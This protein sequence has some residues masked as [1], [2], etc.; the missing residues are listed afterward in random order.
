MANDLKIEDRIEGMKQAVLRS[1]YFD[2]RAFDG[3]FDLE[4]PVLTGPSQLESDLGVCAQ[5]RRRI[6][7]I[8]ELLH[9][10]VVEEVLRLDEKIRD[11]DR[12]DDLSEFLRAL[13]EVV[14]PLKEEK[15]FVNVYGEL[16]STYIL[17]LYRR[18]APG[19]DSPLIRLILTNIA[20]RKA[21]EM[22]QQW[23]ETALR[24]LNEKVTIAV[25]TKRHTLYALITRGLKVLVRADIEYQDHGKSPEAL[26][27]EVTNVLL[28]AGVR[29]TEVTD[30]VCGGGDIG[31]LPDGIY[32]LTQ[33]VRDESRRRLPHSSLNLGALVAWELRELLAKQ[34]SGRLNVSLCNP[35][36]FSTLRSEDMSS[37]LK[38]ESRELSKNLRGYVKVTPL[39]SVSSLISEIL[40]ISRDRLNLV[41]LTLDGLFA[42]VVRKTGPRLIRELAAQEANSLLLDFDFTKI[43]DRLREE[44]FEIPGNLS[45]A[46]PETGTGVREICELLMI[47][48]SGKISDELKRELK[49]VVD[50]YARQVARVLEMA[51]AGRPSERPHF[52]AI[53]TTMALDPYFQTL[54]AKV[55]VRIDNPFTPMLV[56]DSLE[57]E[58][59][60]ANHLFELYV[61]GEGDRRL[62]F[63]VESRSI[64]KALQILGSEGKRRK[65]VFSFDSLLTQVQRSVEEG[66]F[67]R[68]NLVLVG[69]DNEDALEAVSNAKYQG[70]LDRIV[71]IGDPSDIRAA[72]HRTRV[73]LSPGEDKNL[74]IIPIDPLAGSAEEKKDSV[75][76]KFGAFLKENSDFIVMKGSLDTAKLLRQALKIYRPAEGDHE[77]RKVLASHTALFEL[78]NGRF[79]ALSDAAVNPSFSSAENLVLA[80][81]N[82]LDVVRTV[83]DR[84]SVLK[85]AIITAV[86][87]ETKAIPATLLAGDAERKAALLESQ[88]GPLI[89]EGPLS[90]DLA[91]VPEVA[92]EK[93]YQ[94]RIQGDANCL[95]A[96]EINT[97]NVLYKMLS[98]TMGSLGFLIQNGAIITAGPG[99]VPIVLTSRGDTAS[100]KFNS[101]LLAM[102]YCLRGGKDRRRVPDVLKLAG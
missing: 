78:P 6:K 77:D 42:S 58:Y 85:V 26:A 14:R 47:M 13:L 92:Q 23:L 49:Y 10:A 1:G 37:F 94:G 97:A 44:Q 70:L 20:R 89:V 87:K 88:Y 2:P 68:A 7:E 34:G 91:T 27:L 29:L 43:V 24:R 51:S 33:K 45:L 98:K 67:S 69:A 84:D 102:A 100:T 75:A 65:Y 15:E 56:L 11:P 9:A 79:Y 55:R 81:E 74:D 76:E 72:L 59:L 80:I 86:E 21:V 101:I 48:G 57:H 22:D 18:G 71:L 54:F 53:T 62:H 5:S 61:N 83:L 36:S 50:S 64:S 17:S 40:G 25:I 82:Q 93:S 4:Q 99:T 66:T 39:K 41:V 30:I 3:E 35:L 12:F 28:R 16:L 32:V 31:T 63:S 8:S 52:I 96:T 38:E 90:F 73:P 95:V 19:R 60:I 46:H